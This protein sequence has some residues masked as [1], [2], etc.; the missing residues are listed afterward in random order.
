[1]TVFLIDAQKHFAP[2]FVKMSYTTKIML[3]IETLDFVKCLPEFGKMMPNKLNNFI[4]WFC[5]S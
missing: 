5:F 3:L 4:L 1:M 2:F